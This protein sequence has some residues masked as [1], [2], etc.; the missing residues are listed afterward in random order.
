MCINY[1]KTFWIMYITYITVGNL[2]TGRNVIFEISKKEIENFN[3]FLNFNLSLVSPKSNILY[4]FREKWR[5]YWFIHCTGWIFKVDIFHL[6]AENP[7]Y[8]LRKSPN[9]L[10]IVW[11]LIIPKEAMA[12][13]RKKL[14]VFLKQVKQ[15]ENTAFLGIFFHFLHKIIFLNIF[16]YGFYQL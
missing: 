3:L 11:H 14:H 16:Y 6:S 9:F 13:T 4:C 8:W 15:C 10:V 2:E 1:A 5:F 12:K 7:Q